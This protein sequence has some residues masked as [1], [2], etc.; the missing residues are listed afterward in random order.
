MLRSKWFWVL[1]IIVG[2]LAVF[3]IKP[4]NEIKVSENE[5]FIIISKKEL[6]LYVCQALNHDIVR[7]A[8]YPVCLAKNY[9]QKKREGDNKTPETSWNKP[10]KITD[11]HDSS[12]WKHDFND[13]RGSILAYGPWFLRLSTKRFNHIGIHGSTNNENSIPGRY[14]EGCIRMHDEDITELKEKYAFIGMNV[15][16]KHEDEGLLSF[17]EKYY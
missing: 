2:G 1:L 6:K 3:L 12:T 14:S 13:G 4:S 11:I 5:V 7:L 9:G 16:I 10:V 8:E 15:Y 17:E